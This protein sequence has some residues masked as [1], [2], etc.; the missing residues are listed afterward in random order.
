MLHAAAALVQCEIK[1]L[2]FDVEALYKALMPSTEKEI[3]YVHLDDTQTN[4]VGAFLDTLPDMPERAQDLQLHGCTLI[5]G[6]KLLMLLKP[7]ETSTVCLASQL[8]PSHER[9]QKPCFSCNASAKYVNDG[10]TLQCL[11][12][13][14]QLCRACVRHLIE[15][16]AALYTGPR[17]FY[18]KSAAELDDIFCPRC[19]NCNA[20]RDG[21][22]YR[23]RARMLNIPCV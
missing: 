23:V 21:D 5:I 4:S 6:H 22:L 2:P 20:K 19:P 15:E 11:H 1:E 7:S 10:L 12:C 16:R 13:T 8:H 14:I 17:A 9:R 18:G 3:V